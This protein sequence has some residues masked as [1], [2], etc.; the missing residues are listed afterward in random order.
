[1]ISRRNSWKTHAAHNLIIFWEECKIIESSAKTV[2][3][4]FSV[5]EIIFWTNPTDSFEI[6]TNISC[7]CTDNV[8]NALLKTRTISITNLV[9][10]NFYEI[11]SYPTG[12]LRPIPY[13]LTVRENPVP[14]NLTLLE[15]LC[16]WK[17]DLHGSTAKKSLVMSPSSQRI[18]IEYLQKCFYHCSSLVEIRGKFSTGRR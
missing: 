17:C 6:S 14:A 4:T 1:M 8:E 2:S 16:I 11:D 9:L 7:T 18:L 5:F 12:T 13:I 15:F 10:I 3:A